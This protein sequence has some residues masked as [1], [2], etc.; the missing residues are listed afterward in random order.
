VPGHSKRVHGL[1]VAG[2]LFSVDLS[3]Q[4]AVIRAR[5]GDSEAFSSLVEVY[6]LPLVRFARSIVGDAEAEDVVQESLVAAW[7]KLRTLENP[8]SFHPWMLRIVSRRCFGRK[9]GLARFLPWLT[10]PGLPE[11]WVGASTGEFEVERV[12]SVLPPRQRAVM[13]LT[14]I[15]GMSDSEIG[16]ALGIRAA[17]ARSHRQR[18]R[19]ALASL[20][21]KGGRASEEV[22]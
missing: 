21:R 8:A 9:R 2:T 19:Q 6:W 14:V 3:D 7:K 18:A 1:G 17:S 11:P 16:A 4:A 12:L 13:H 10:G 22:A 20:L 15:E 5:E